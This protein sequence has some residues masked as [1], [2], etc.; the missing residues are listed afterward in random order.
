MQISYC[1]SLDYFMWCVFE[2]EVSKCPHITLTSIKVMTSAVVTVV[3][4][5]T[6]RS[7]F[8]PPWSFSL[9]LRLLSRPL[10]FLSNKC[11]YY[12]HINYSWNFHQNIFT[13]TI[14]FI[15]L[16]AAIEFV[17]IYRPHPVYYIV[18]CPPFNR[19][20]RSRPVTLNSHG[21]LLAAAAIAYLF[22]MDCLF[23]G[24]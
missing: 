14:S 10:G 24:Y 6:G 22:Y 16:N 12:M 11:L 20:P 23:H 1:N 7:S 5:V 15:V 21:A 4:V 9:G 8:T 2:R 13:L 19:R 17:L 3:T 18:W